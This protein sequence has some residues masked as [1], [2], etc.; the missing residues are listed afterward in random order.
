[1]PLLRIIQH[2]PGITPE[3]EEHIR[4][5][6]AP[7]SED[8]YLYIV[9][10]YPLVK[11]IVDY[12][13]KPLYRLYPR[14]FLAEIKEQNP[15]AGQFFYNFIAYLMNHVY[16]N[17]NRHKKGKGI[18]LAVGLYTLAHR[19]RMNSYIKNRKRKQACEKVN[20]ICEEA[21][22]LGY[23]SDYKIVH[24][25]KSEDNPWGARLEATINKAKLSPDKNGSNSTDT[26]EK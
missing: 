4:T 13:D 6:G 18:P 16:S 24:G 7:T 20:T 26:A 2:Y 21:K 3:E 17:S 15:K 10:G 11:G 14:N 1:L 22:K 9:A 25:E 19:L 8:G 5:T 23:L 12:K